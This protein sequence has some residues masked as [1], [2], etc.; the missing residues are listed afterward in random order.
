MSLNLL[1]RLHFS[2]ELA[3]N[4][5]IRFIHQG[6]ELQDSETLRNYQIRDQTVIHCHI[7]TPRHP[8]PNRFD[9]STAHS[10]FNANGI[11]TSPIRMSQHFF[12]CVAFVLALT[13]YLRVHYRVLFTPISTILLILVTMIFLIFTCAPLFRPA[14]SSPNRRVSTHVQH[15]HQHWTLQ[16]DRGEWTQVFFYVCTNQY[17]QFERLDAHLLAFSLSLCNLVKYRVICCTSCVSLSQL[18]SSRMNLRW[19]T[20]RRW[21]VLSM[22]PSLFELLRKRISI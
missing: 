4:K 12:L 14:Q 18:K 17:E 15:V 22:I 5:I 11:D 19:R 7:S 2:E 20:R 21:S 1:F 10:H 16:F 9:D 3:N 8:S 13:W 6:R